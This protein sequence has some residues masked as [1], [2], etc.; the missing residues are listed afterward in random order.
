MGKN[1]RKQYK[2]KSKTTPKTKADKAFSRYI[3]LRDA[4]DY[5]LS[6][7]VNLSSFSRPED[8]IG[9]C[10]TCGV[11]KS[12]IGMDNGH[13]KGR[14]IGG[15]SGTYFDERNCH[16]QC[17]RCNA[18]GGGAP[19]EYRE[20]VIEK[21]GQ[22][23]LEELNTKHRMPANFSDLAMKALEVWAKEQYNNLVKRHLF[24]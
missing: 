14:G 2:K 13:Y 3:R 4:I 24:I 7:R 23:V 6:H 11:V 17:K 8:V 21:Y 9:K 1:W 12:W 22:V 19:D 20:F 15:G 16:L 5:C 10:C 18:F